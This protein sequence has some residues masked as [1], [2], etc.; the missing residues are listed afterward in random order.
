MTKNLLVVYTDGA[1]NH[2]GK[3]T[4]DCGIGII[5]ENYRF[6]TYV[7]LGYGQYIGVNDMNYAEL[8]A[9]KKALQLCMKICDDDTHVIIKTDSKYVVDRLSGKITNCKYKILLAEVKSLMFM[10]PSLAIE[11]VTG[12]QQLVRREV[13]RIAKLCRSKRYRRLS[14]LPLSNN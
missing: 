13:D 14:C 9:V 12:K 11:K 4:G 1:C 8:Y 6:H 7:G 10:F 2:L 3:A 5:I